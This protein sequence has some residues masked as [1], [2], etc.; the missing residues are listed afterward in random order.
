MFDKVLS[1]LKR[2]LMVLIGLGTSLGF[3]QVAGPA[4]NS[5]SRALS[6]EKLTSQP[7]MAARVEACHLVK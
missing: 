3:L 5:S 1:T 2:K 6:A 7:G 4:G